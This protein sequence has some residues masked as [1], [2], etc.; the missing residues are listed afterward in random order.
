LKSSS[1]TRILKPIQRLSKG[2][3][4]T[5][6]PATDVLAGVFVSGSDVLNSKAISDEQ[7]PRSWPR[8]VKTGCGVFRLCSLGPKESEARPS[9][10]RRR[11]GTVMEMASPHHRFG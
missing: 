8:T 1:T 11:T 10:C 6:T 9:S 2:L 5:E 3:R 4:K 7:P